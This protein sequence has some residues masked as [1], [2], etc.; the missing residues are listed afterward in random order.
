MRGLF[1][2]PLFCLSHGAVP[3]A[4]HREPEVCLTPECAVAAASIIQSM[5]VEADPCED[6]YRFACGGWMD[7]NVIP[8]GMS[9]WGAFYELRD[10][11]NNALKMI[12]TDPNASSSTAVTSLKAMYNGCMD[13][14]TIEAAGIPALL[15]EALGPQAE[16]GGWPMLLQPGS[17]DETK[18]DASTTMGD[19]RNGQGLN[20]LLSIFVYL[21]DFNTAHNVIYVDQPDLGLP[22]SMYLDLDSYADYIAAYKT[23][24]VD[25][26]RVMVREL[27]TA[28]PD[29]QLA[30]AADKIF[31]FEKNVALRMSPAS[32]RRNSTAMYNPMTIAELKALMPNMDWDKYLA[33]VFV[34]TDVSVGDDETVI[35]VEPEYLQTAQEIE[36]DMETIANYMYWRSIM[37]VNG[38]LTQELRDI[39]FKFS[40]A[41]TGVT[42]S[43][44][45]WMTCTAK[46][47]NAFGFAAAHEYIKANF[48]E[49]SKADADAMVENLRS[50]FKELVS[51]TDWMD[52][53]T[54]AKAAEKADQMLQLI[55][56]PDWLTDPSE[57]DS[58]YLTAPATS[59]QEHFMNMIS[60]GHW[61]AIQDLKTLREEPK[62]DI[63][64]MH[65][66]IV[67]AWYSPNHNTITFPAGIL[68]APFF[69]G[70]WPRYLNYGAMGMVI[71]HEITHG[72]DDQG[73]QYD[74]TGSLAP[75][76][77]EETIAAFGGKAQCFIDQYSNYTVPELIPILG[78]EDAHL[79]GENTQGENIADNGGIHESFRAYQHSVESQGAEPALPGLTQFTPE[80]MFFISNA[81]VWCEISTPE[82]LLGQV[83]GDPHSPGRFRVIGPVGN[84]EDFQ[85]A[86]GCPADS[87]MNRGDEKCLLW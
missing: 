70:G 34:D 18:F 17:W 86:Y 49:E 12:V 55:G 43:P 2:F 25:T 69:K 73:R 36:V 27:A 15:L 29:E 30:M 5:D 63:W 71:G 42:E 83:L 35:V 24:M 62:R 48:A 40:S 56:Y 54:Q 32:D 51:E 38:E 44:A 67:N 79:N 26:A 14:E 85:T 23:Y 7:S 77:S 87:A 61:A 11:V 19:I 4:R 66:A 8:D 46:A 53:A 60:T 58:Y 64:L 75:W 9:K 6:F 52:S 84:S 21:D 74:G 82:A 81:Q 72:F 59:E 13:T 28:V 47:V 20:V 45:R 22:L 39:A 68:Q 57:V 31:D 41:M 10:Q 80:Q 76:W 3:M 65:P 78:E 16:E 37:Q 1:F 33:A 50:A